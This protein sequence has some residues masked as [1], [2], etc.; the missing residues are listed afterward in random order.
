M[1][2]DNG[3]KQEQ[4]RFEKHV[5]KK[6]KQ[7][8]KK[9]IRFKKPQLLASYILTQEPGYVWMDGV[10]VKRK[11]A[12]LSM[13]A[14]KINEMMD[15]QEFRRAVRDQIP[16]ATKEKATGMFDVLLYKYY[17]AQCELPRGPDHKSLVVFGQI[18]GKYDPM[19]KI[20]ISGGMTFTEEKEKV[21]K[22]EIVNAL[23]NRMTRLKEGGDNGD[24]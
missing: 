1:P 23:E 3:D 5:D 14:E 21:F 4:E 18:S 22:Q 24:G 15:T 9:R 17:L 8:R 7:E 19:Q 10:A 11:F 6:P 13:S 2:D 16:D 20:D 12:D